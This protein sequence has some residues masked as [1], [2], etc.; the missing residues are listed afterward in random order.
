M[1]HLLVVVVRYRIH[2]LLPLKSND[3]VTLLEEPLCLQFLHE[4]CLLK[5]LSVS[6]EKVLVSQSYV[7]FVLSVDSELLRYQNV[8]VTFLNQLVPRYNQIGLYLD[9]YKSHDIQNIYKGKQLVFRLLQHQ[10]FLL[11]Y[12]I[13]DFLSNPLWS[14]H[15]AMPPLLLLYYGAV[16]S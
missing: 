15:F 4:Q 13:T 9:L 12:H 7:L 6:S 5:M 14:F 10:Q 8:L 1:D 11:S 3:F 2:L 16:E